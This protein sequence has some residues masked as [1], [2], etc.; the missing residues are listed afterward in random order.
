MVCTRVPISRNSGGAVNPGWSPRKGRRFLSPFLGASCVGTDP[1]GLTADQS[2][3][4]IQSLTPP[5]KPLP[6]KTRTQRLGLR[7]PRGMSVK[8][9]IREPI[10]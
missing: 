1:V 9:L 10:Q 3:L 7:A 2:P 4:P 5:P 8:P 6:V